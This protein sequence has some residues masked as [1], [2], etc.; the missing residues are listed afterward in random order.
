LNS[1]DILKH[2]NTIAQTSGKKDKIALVAK[3]IEDADFQMVLWRALDPRETYGL[4]KRPDVIGYGSGVFNEGTW[5]LL[6]GLAERKVTGNDAIARVTAEL[7]RL[8]EHSAELLWRVI[9]KDLRAGFGA[10]TVNKAHPGLIF[11]APYMRCSLPKEIKWDK[12]A[13]SLGCYSQL[14]ADG[15]FANLDVT[16]DG[17]VIISTRD[18]NIYP[19]HEENGLGDVVNIA[20]RRLRK[21]TRT[22]G[23][24]VV[25]RRAHDE[26]VFYPRE[27]SNG[28]VNS[29]MNGGQLEPGDCVAFFA[30]DQIPLSA[31]QPKYKHKEAYAV[32]FGKLQEQLRAGEESPFMEVIETRMVYSLEEAYTHYSEVL[33]RG[34]KLEGTVVKDP[35]GIWEDATSRSQV[36]L[37]LKIP[38]ELQITGFRPGEGKNEATF[39]ALECQTSDHLLEVGVSGFTDK[40]RA[41]IWANC[42][43]MLG[44]IVTVNSNGVMYPKKEGD[45]HSLFLPTFGEIR[46]DKSEADSLERVIAQFA[47]AVQPKVGV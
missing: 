35:N 10:S 11:V 17:T 38:V 24:L 3:H 32:R 20:K 46:T 37:K 44:K 36:K 42:E 5:A 43:T 15:S 29:L 12:F 25:Y 19:T 28:K 7:S 26:R 30:W 2:L 14:K 47:S 1:N 16:E 8:T 39:G 23:E 13:W 33:G 4:A 45:L 21:A 31:A 34:L 40:V 22:H 27:E 18:G 41:D 9:T 6:R